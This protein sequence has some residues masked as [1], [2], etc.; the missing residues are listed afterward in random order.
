MFK[1]KI[2]GLKYPENISQLIRIK[3]DYMGFIFY[4]KSKRYCEGFINQEFMAEIPNSIKKVGVFVNAN[5]VE[6]EKIKTKYCLDFIQLHGDEKPQFCHKLKELGIG[7]IK[8]FQIHENFDFKQINE[9][10]PSCDFFLFDT[11]SGQYGGSGNQFD[12]NILRKYDNEKSFFL[13]G[14]IEFNDIDKIINI[15]YL[16]IHAI[17]IN[18]KFETRPAL[19]D[20]DKIR[21]FIKNIRKIATET[22]KQITI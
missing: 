15:S 4:P 8:A 11:K 6:I 3:P 5:L 16:N 21:A 13:S 17:D 2:C 22:N 10:K 14:G 19:K 7:I 20:A 12:W 18:S 9:Y 1:V